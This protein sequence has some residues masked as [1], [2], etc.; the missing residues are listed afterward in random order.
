MKRK[1]NE[2]VINIIRMGQGAFKYAIDKN[3]KSLFYTLCDDGTYRVIDN[4][5]GKMLS[6]TCGTLEDCAACVNK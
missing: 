2:D 4:R 5:K 1:V 3:I 6:Y